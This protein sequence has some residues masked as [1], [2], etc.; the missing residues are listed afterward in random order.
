MIGDCKDEVKTSSLFPMPATVRDADRAQI[1]RPDVDPVELAGAT[2]KPRRHGI[3]ER[4]REEVRF[5]ILAGVAHAEVVRRTGVS[6]GTVSV[7]RQELKGKVPV[8]RNTEAVVCVPTAC[9]TPSDGSETE[10][11]VI[12]NIGGPGRTRTCD[13]TVMSG[14]F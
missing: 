12:Q 7:I 14:A 13:N 11:Q 10:T 9:P 3:G 4:K 2:S 1:D 6:S 8:Y 5:L